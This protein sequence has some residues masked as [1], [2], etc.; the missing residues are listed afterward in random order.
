[1]YFLKFSFLKVEIDEKIYGNSE[2]RKKLKILSQKNNEIE[3]I[4]FS[5]LL[6][7]LPSKHLDLKFEEKVC[8]FKIFP[9]NS[10]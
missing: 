4:S 7:D 6:D 1:M 3:P 8:F 5:F 9:F 2:M 10:E